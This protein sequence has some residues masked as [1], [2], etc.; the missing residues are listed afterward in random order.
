MAKKPAAE[1]SADTIYSVY[2]FTGE[3]DSRRTTAVKDLISRMVSPGSADFDLEKFDG[4]KTS[5]E[6]ILSAAATLPFGSDRKVVVVNRVDRMSGDDQE[7][8]AVFVKKPM[9]HSSL[10]LLSGEG[11]STNR[12]GSD[13]D[14]GKRK[15]LRPLLSA[16]VKKHG[17]VVNFAKMRAQDVSTLAGQIVRGHGK[18]IDPSA[19]QTLAR[20]T[21][22]HPSMLEREIEKLVTYIDDRE[23]IT[24]D[25]VEKLVT[26]SAEERVFPLI[27]AVAAGRTEQA[28]QLL[29]DTF[30]ASS[31]P[32]NEVLKVV[33]LM[34]RHFRM[35]YQFK[36]MM[37]AG[38]RSFNTAT[39]DLRSM[40]MREP[41]PLSIPEWQRN[42]LSD[43][44]R[45]FT[46]DEL[47]RCLRHMLTCEL[48]VKGQ[49]Q[50]GGSPRLNLEMLI[51]RL[52]QRK[53]VPL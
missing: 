51:L 47:R 45:Q 38:G 9:P 53:S 3:M 15:G 20:L 32:D 50:E 14:S 28:V 40:L 42:K 12:K 43:Q 48:A 24:M 1:Q 44:A 10:I 37:Q 41:N 30:A 52:S 8:I 2:L 21:E 35:L 46:L 4:D 17:S 39:D 23:T 36:F 13:D 27:D 11:T 7:K 26:K 6:N 29:D 16:A 25:D 31:K 5:A 49:S 33:S 22:A 34:A 18:K 19:L